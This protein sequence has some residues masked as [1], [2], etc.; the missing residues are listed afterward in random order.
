MGRIKGS[1]RIARRWHT[2]E[3]S[4]LSPLIFSSRHLFSDFNSILFA[5]ISWLGSEERIVRF[6]D[7]RERRYG[8][9]AAIVP[10]R[11]LRRCVPHALRYLI[12]G[13]ARVER[14]LPA[15]GPAVLPF[16]GDAR[17][18]ADVVLETAEGLL[19]VDAYAFGGYGRY[20]G[21]NLALVQTFAPQHL[22]PRP[23]EVDRERPQ[24]VRQG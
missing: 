18:T 20:Q 24:H 12:D 23:Q 11:G 1:R 3:W 15:G 9:G 16:E 2:S 10:L 4:R 21:G 8:P 5:L 6:I 22:R 7:P 14:E 17:F 13:D 19:G